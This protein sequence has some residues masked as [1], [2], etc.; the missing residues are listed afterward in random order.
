METE[1]AL[2]YGCYLF[3]AGNFFVILFLSYRLVVS[4]NTMNIFI[5]FYALFSAVGVLLYLFRE[6]WEEKGET[7][8][9]SPLR[10]KVLFLSFF[11][12]LAF[13]L[14]SLRDSLYT[15]PLSFYLGITGAATVLGIQ[16]V[17]SPLKGP[18]F[19]LFFV[20]LLALMATVHGSSYYVNPYLVG[21]DTMY[22]Y[23]FVERI[24]QSGHRT[25]ETLHYYYYPAGQLLYAASGGVLGLG[26]DSFALTGLLFST[27]NV[28]I[29][30]LIGTL[31][32]GR[33]L[34]LM[35]AFFGIFCLPLLYFSYSYSI[36]GS[37]FGLALLAFY[38]LIRFGTKG[39]RGKRHLGVWILFWIP[40]LSLFFF[41]PVTAMAM[42][43]ILGCSYLAN[44]YF[45]RGLESFHPFASYAVGIVAY[46][47]FVH[48][49]L[50]E[51]IVRVLFIPGDTAPLPL[52]IV[53]VERVTIKFYLESILAYLNYD[54]LLMLGLLGL[55]YL[56]R[57]YDSHSLTFF[58]STAILLS[59]P[60]VS[61]FGIT[62]SIDPLRFLTLVT[63]LL[64]VPAAVGFLTIA[65][66][67][68]SPGR[69]AGVL[70]FVAGMAFFSLTS[71]LTWDGN[72]ILED[73]IQV[74]TNYL[75]HTTIA[76]HPFLEGLPDGSSLLMDDR[77]VT[78][79]ADATRGIHALPGKQIW[80]MTKN[81]LFQKKGYF[82]ANFP[83]IDRWYWR[84]EADRSLFVEAFGRMD[85]LYDNGPVRVYF[86]RARGADEEERR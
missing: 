42:A 53:P 25:R 84:T 63:I 45:P 43:L 18:Y 68:R 82:V 67:Q 49:T 70:L 19:R 12:F 48:I 29:L 72:G 2:R 59:I 22:H 13:S 10:E 15:K 41:H 60:A 79:L 76:V 4:P 69:K 58:F 36:M 21:P 46:L 28:L 73:Q 44:H 34:G 33:R 64:T 37:S 62:G 78:Y 5:L 52:T 32:R 16:I 8:P 61:F 38:A 1:R 57:R 23:H 66:S 40:A 31:F 51:D 74:P 39:R 27:F 6:R 7:S 35:A 3:L 26:R 50:F 85:L 83:N 20:E 17:S 65:R 30:Y 80:R 81:N 11:L 75:S 86:Q 77:T 24:L 47:M 56:L 9:P 55:L 71:Y 14:H 54:L